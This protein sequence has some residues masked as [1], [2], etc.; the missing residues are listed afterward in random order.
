M[1]LSC[2]QASPEQLQ[3][4]LIDE[5][6]GLPKLQKP[7]QYAQ[8]LKDVRLVRSTSSSSAWI[9]PVSSQDAGVVS[10]HIA[11]Q[12]ESSNASVQC[13]RVSASRELVGENIEQHCS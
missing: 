2:L 11:Y 8:L 3:R 4:Q 5:K 13:T 10:L 9:A 1:T 12:A 7:M 6:T